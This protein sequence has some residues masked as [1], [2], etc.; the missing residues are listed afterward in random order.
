MTAIEAWVIDCSRPCCA[1]KTATPSLAVE[2][3]SGEP[4][5]EVGKH[6]MLADRHRQPHG[7][8]ETTR[9]RIIALH[10]VDDDV[11]RDEGLRHRARVAA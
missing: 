7:V 8:V 1:V 10:H 4:L 6:L 2:Y 3:L 11:A 5:P 9:V